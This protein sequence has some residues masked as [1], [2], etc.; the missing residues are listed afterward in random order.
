MLVLTYNFLFFILLSY[1]TGNPQLFAYRTVVHDMWPGAQGPANDTYFIG[2]NP[3]YTLVVDVAPGQHSGTSA[4]NSV[5]LLFSRHLTV[6]EQ[7]EMSEHDE[8][9][10]GSDYFGVHVYKLV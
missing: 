2:S 4:V 3:Q 6:K 9:N 8:A 7:S 5:W 1:F 10:G